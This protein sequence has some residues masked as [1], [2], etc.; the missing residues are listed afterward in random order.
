[1]ANQI[2]HLDLDTF[3]VSVERIL[4]PSLKGKPV[5]VGGDPRI[6]RG[7]VASCSYEA[8]AFGVHSAQSIREA[9]KLCPQAVYVR[10]SH[11]HYG[12]YSRLVTKIVHS[13]VPRYQKSSIDEFY[14]DLSHTERSHGNTYEWAQKIQ[15]TIIGETGLPISFGLAT[16]KLV[17]KV[18]TTQVAKHTQ[19]RHHYVPTGCEQAFFAPLSVRALPGIGEVTEK[20]INEHGI[21]TL[22]QL[23]ELPVA[24]AE[25]YFGNHGRALQQ[26]ARGIDASPVHQTH[27]QKGYSR[28]Q[29]FR[30]TNDPETLGAILLALSAQL[31]SDLRHAGYYAGNLALK[32]RYSDFETITRMAR[33][34]ET[35]RDRDIYQ[36]TAKLFRQ[37]W[38]PRRQVRLLGVHATELV[39]HIE[40]QQLFT[41]TERENTLY[42]IIDTLRSKYGM[43]SVHYAA[44][45]LR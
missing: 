7:V 1:M 43:T 4:D 21:K 18:A 9:Y 30:D 3:F 33:C 45:E 28:E 29:T 13:L 35:N 27:E 25:Q 36:H 12:E 44:T 5:I 40:Q 16:N 6:G 26:R 15:R 17:A 32:L 20:K 8:R 39:E 31:G 14:I 38:N 41:E 23:A 10:G 42:P 2:I 11:E 19:E 34:S 22:G 24:L 37:H